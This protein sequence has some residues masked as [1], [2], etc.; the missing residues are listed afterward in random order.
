MKKILFLVVIGFGVLCVRADLL[1]ATSDAERVIDQ[2]YATEL[3]HDLAKK[4]LIAI[5]ND[6]NLS[7][8]DKERRIRKEFLSAEALTSD[9]A[10]DLLLYTP[11][12]SWRIHSLA[13]AYDFDGR[14]ESLVSRDRLAE[15][16][17]KQTIGENRESTH[18]RNRTSTGEKSGNTYGG[19]GVEMKFGIFPKIS[20]SGGAEGK[21]MTTESETSSDG[22]M[23]AWT[24]QDQASLNSHY[25]SVMKELSKTELS[26]LHIRFVIEFSNSTGKDMIVPSGC[27]VPVYAG[28]SHCVDAKMESVVDLN[29]P[30]YGRVD[31]S[32]RGNL[33]T[34]AAR[35][36]IDFMRTQAPAIVPERSALLPI[37]STDGTIRDAV[38]ESKRVACAK[39]VCGNYAWNVRKVWNEKPVT[40]QQALTAVNSRYAA[41]PFA[42]EGGKLVAICGARVG[43]FG[44]D[45]VPCIETDAGVSVVGMDLSKPLIL[46]EI[47]FGVMDVDNIFYSEVAWNSFTKESQG[48][49]I[50]RLRALEKNPR[51]QVLLAFC[52]LEGRGVEKISREG[53]GVVSQGGR[54]GEC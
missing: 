1:K 46:D 43:D 26:G 9:N 23:S 25:E 50:E 36:L 30:A 49:L 32:F 27:T 29:I 28:N 45:K 13:V 44:L 38:N 42:M 10:G 37:R 54:T 31:I 6:V 3:S 5:L 41:P 40:L 4:K 48:E 19:I 20:A 47:R 8:A 51:A 18:N 39:I 7:D 15:S 34:T 53:R 24:R 16:N 12:L 52:Y 21:L 17:R 14:F 33:A 2:R 11:V 22:M 35:N